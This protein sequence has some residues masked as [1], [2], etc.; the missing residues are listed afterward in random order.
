MKTVTKKLGLASRI[1]FED[2]IVDKNINNANIHQEI[3]I[4][5][6]NEDICSQSFQESQD[7][8]EI[9]SDTELSKSVARVGNVIILGRRVTKN[10]EIPSEY[11]GSSQS[12]SKIRKGKTKSTR[13]I[14]TELEMLGLDVKDGVKELNG[15]Y[16]VFGD[17]SQIFRKYRLRNTELP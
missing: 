15:E 16:D 11:E 9:N 8:T 6:E 13:R 7:F 10:K 17:D 2:D 4:K 14:K 5:D 12:E 1:L 3:S